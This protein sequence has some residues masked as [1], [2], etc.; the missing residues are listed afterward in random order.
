MAQDKARRAR[1][2]VSPERRQDGTVAT[3]GDRSTGG[4]TSV[5]GM[6][7]MDG[8]DGQDG[9][10]GQPGPPGAVGPSGPAGAPGGP[11]GPP[12]FDGLDGADGQDGQAGAIGLTG[13]SGVSG[14]MGFMGPP[15]IDGDDGLEG[16]PGLPSRDVAQGGT[17]ALVTP[18]ILSAKPVSFLGQFRSYA[19]RSAG[20]QSIPNITT[21]NLQYT[22][23]LYD[24]GGVHS[25]SV[26]TTRFTV[27]V[28]GAGVW[29]LMANVIL[30]TASAC[31][32]LIRCHKNGS[33]SGLVASDVPYVA[34][35]GN[36]SNQLSVIDIAADGDYYEFDVYQDTGGAVNAGWGLGGGF[37]IAIKL[38]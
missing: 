2:V 27:P 15:G 24:T 36:I 1:H 23:N 29:L 37:G 12:G 17:I 28:G 30:S 9:A 18:L 14:P 21:T 20:P 25:T 3:F 6:P 7:G 13:P 16:F 4:R 10:P 11:M 31:R 38:F 22:D 8:D 32:F 5:P 33:G 35:V 19:W 26:N 34:S